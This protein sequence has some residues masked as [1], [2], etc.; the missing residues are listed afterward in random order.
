MKLCQML[1]RS[2]TLR[3]VFFPLCLKHWT[4]SRE[5]MKLS[6][7][8]CVL[9]NPVW[10]SLTNWCNTPCILRAKIFVIILTGAVVTTRKFKFEENL[11]S[12][13]NC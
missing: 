11:K 10:P 12:F 3:L 9:T 13:I 6:A 4:R 8:H 1:S 7:M 5:Y 2:P